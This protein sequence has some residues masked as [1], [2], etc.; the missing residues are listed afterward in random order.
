MKTNPKADD[1]REDKA[2]RTAGGS[3]VYAAAQGAEGLLRR[4]VLACLLWESNFYEAGNVGAEQIASLIPQVEPEKVAALAIEARR[5]Q[6]LR[7]VPLFLAR[8]MARHETHRGL[9]GRVLSEVILRPDELTEFLAIYWKDGRQPLSGQVKK[10]LAAAFGRFNAYQLAKYNRD[11][12][13]KLRD[14]MFLVHPKPED[15]KAETY[16]QLASDTLPVP[17][18]WEVALSGGADKR[19]TWERLI[20]ESKLGALAFMRNLRNMEKASVSP[21]VIRLGFAKIKP[22][23]LLP[24]NFI[25]AA[26]AVPGW[27]REIEDLMLRCLG[28]TKKLAGRTILV[29]DVSGSMHQ[30]VSA[31]SE[32]TPLDISAALA[33]L[34]TEVCSSIALYATAGNDGTRIH[35]TA[36]LAPRRGFAIM[37]QIREAYAHMGGGGIFT[38]QCLEYIREHER[39]DPDRI[40]VFSDSQDCD[41]PGRQLPAPFGKTNYIVDVSAHTRGINYDG[42]WTAEISGWSEKFLQYIAA[43]EG[44]SFGQEQD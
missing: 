1:Y 11:E 28:E 33:M 22:I 6:K 19:E 13:V 14:V 43:L 29:V 42:V 7:H 25:S 38:R 20:Q 4:A 32:M 36:G 41:L 18:T 21:D 40:V 31:K 23:W 24:I 2:A 9:V 35:E 44:Q 30:G 17:D 15:G 8:E 3:G 26:R 27:E 10:G 16:A 5:E 39:E 12:K 37:D 34:A